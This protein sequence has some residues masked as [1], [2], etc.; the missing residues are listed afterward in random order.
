MDIP[1]PQQ[2]HGRSVQSLASGLA[3]EASVLEIQ[4]PSGAVQRSDAAL[5]G[6]A[7]LL[8]VEPGCRAPICPDPLEDWI[9]LEDS[10]E[11]RTVRR[12]ALAEL[13]RSYSNQSRQILQQVV[14]DETDLIHSRGNW[15]ALPHIEA[16]L[17]RVLLAREGGVA[18]REVLLRV[19]WPDGAPKRNDLDVHISRLR[20][21]LLGVGLAIRTVRSRGYALDLA[22]EFEDAST[23]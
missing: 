20:K 18:S 11:D 9:R 2:R 5:S 4:W 22:P 19:G 21:R 23:E 16:E 13:V 1:G 14:V 6:R 7:R 3:Q 15:V 8:L 17:V 10:L 12:Q